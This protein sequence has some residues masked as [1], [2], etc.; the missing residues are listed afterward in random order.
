[1]RRASQAATET[2]SDGRQ[3]AS[4]GELLGDVTRDVSVLV[5]QEVQLAKAELRQEAMS[6]G[7]A[8]GL[9]GAAALAGFMV[10]LFLSYAFWWGLA[11]VIDQGWAALV[12]AVVWGVLGAGLAAVA[13][14]R[15]REVKGMRRTTETAREFP[16]ALK[17]HRFDREGQR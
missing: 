7:K 16:A 5:R 6:A 13:R 15:M 14:N 3:Q 1:M 10:L 17:G 8:I 11:N 9:F 4:I 12:V 2:K